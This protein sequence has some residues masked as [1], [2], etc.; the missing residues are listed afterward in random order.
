MGYAD[1]TDIQFNLADVN[2]DQV[3]DVLD[4]VNMINLVLENN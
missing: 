2:D 3:I 4:I 1:L